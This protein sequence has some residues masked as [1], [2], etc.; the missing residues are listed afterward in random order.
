MQANVFYT[1]MEEMVKKFL[2]VIPNIAAAIAI[3]VIGYIIARILKAVVTKSLTSAKL[4]AKVEELKIPEKDSTV[5]IIGR[6]TFYLVMLFVLLAFFNVLN[7]PIIAGPI[8]TLVNT[9]MEYLPRVGGAAIIIIIAWIIAKILKMVILKGLGL[10]NFDEKLSKYFKGKP[11]EIIARI[12]FY[13][14]LLFAI[15]PILRSL[16]AHFG[17]EPSE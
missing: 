5:D 16:K 12:T 2:L 8:S 14:V 13:L 4:F 15:P 3:L 6:L 7:L 17:D 9:V 10:L 1:S 11:S